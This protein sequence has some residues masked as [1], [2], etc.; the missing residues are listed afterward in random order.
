M[1]SSTPPLSTGGVS[2]PVVTAIPGIS[3]AG[4]AY[5]TSIPVTTTAPT[6]G[7][8]HAG[9]LSPTSMAHTSTSWVHHPTS[10]VGSFGLVPP[11]PAPWP[12]STYASHPPSGGSTAAASWLPDPLTTALQQLSNAVDPE[13]S[14]PNAGMHFRPEFYALHKL[15]NIPL[16]QVDFRKM[17]FKQLLYG[18][19][20]VAQKVRASGYDID[21]YLAHI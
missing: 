5:A 17:S 15:N 13:A 7:P 2:K 20:C 10:H 9:V 14:V 6:L 8:A 1:T 19:M 16:R 4:T 12:S 21:G 11:T 18:M 3:M